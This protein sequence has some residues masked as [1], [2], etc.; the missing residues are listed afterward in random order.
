MGSVIF[1]AVVAALIALA[2]IFIYNNIIARH[3]LVLRAW[4]DVIAYQ[5]Q[6]NKTI[7][8]LEE[9][10]RG[11][12]EFESSLVTRVTE[13][14]S[15]INKLSE[16]RIDPEGLERVSAETS[17]LMAGLRVTIEAYPQITSVTPVSGLMT[18]ISELQENV[19]AALVIFNGNVAEF[20]N[21]ITQF[22]GVLINQYF[23]KKDAV[24]TFSDNRA[25]A[26][27]DYHP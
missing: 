6:F 16:S 21:S 3:N 26:D 5:R 15:S 1:L 14:R 25:S 19:S 10:V 13:L 8:A 18:E 12:K 22:P 2:I 11:Y 4:A 27:F 9:I 17:Q 20:N 23:A 7:P 24:K